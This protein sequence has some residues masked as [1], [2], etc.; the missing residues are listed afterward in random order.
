MT[1]RQEHYLQASHEFLRKAREELQQGDLV[2]ASEKGWGA[3]A[4]IIKGVGENRGWRHNS[5]PS[6]N[7]IAGRLTEE[8]GDRQIATLFSVVSALHTNF[9]ENWWAA[10][11][12]DSGLQDVQLLLEKLEPLLETT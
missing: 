1:T 9:Y 4:Q 5:H 7:A 10:D 2:Q 3:A 6:L 12:V 11:L 8:T